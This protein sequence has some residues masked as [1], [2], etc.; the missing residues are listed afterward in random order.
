MISLLNKLKQEHS[1]HDNLLKKPIQL[2]LLVCPFTLA[3]SSVRV[4]GMLS[5]TNT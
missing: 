1:W 5:M 3:S 4:G 2:E